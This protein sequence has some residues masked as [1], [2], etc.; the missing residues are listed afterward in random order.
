MHQLSLNPDGSERVEYTF[1]GLPVRVS[2]NRLSIFH[3]LAAA[4]HWHDDF[5]ILMA[6]D[7]EMD[8]FVNGQTVHLKKGEAV[9]VNARRLHYGYSAAMRDCGYRF[10]VFHP[11]LFGGF[12]AL[13]SALEAVMRDDGADYWRLGA[14][15]D[16]VMIF[17]ELYACAASGDS[18]HTL[19]KCAELVAAIREAAA[20]QRQER[21][22]SEWLVLRNMTGYIQSHYADRIT[23]NQV[24]A[25]G[26]V[27]RNRCCTLFRE[28]LG[29]SPMEYVNRYRLDKACDMLRG[30]SSVTEAALSN[31]FHG[32]SYFA[33][34]FKRV[35]HTTPREYQ[36]DVAGQGDAP[37][38]EAGLPANLPRSL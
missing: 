3:D 33:E 34:L 15:S 9:F 24:A 19:E 2:A 5:E 32:A 35:Y 12:P 6:T 37:G 29:C 14:A 38:D 20:D 28:N 11:S 10:V 22:G 4:C 8:Y 27:C 23:L 18:L 25:A 21:V 17:S 16:A 13:Q 30:G 26:A 1:E 31:G 36:R 7:G